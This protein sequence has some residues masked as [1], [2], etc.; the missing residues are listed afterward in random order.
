[1]NKSFN[2]SPI[3][4]GLIVLVSSFPSPV[5]SVNNWV[6]GKIVVSYTTE[7]PSNERIKTAMCIKS[8]VETCCVRRPE[9][10]EQNCLMFS[11]DLG[12]S[13]FSLLGKDI[14]LSY[15]ELSPGGHLYSPAGLHLIAGAAIHRVS[16]DRTAG[17]CPRHLVL[18]DA[19]GLF[20]SFLFE[21]GAHT[22]FLSSSDSSLSGESVTMLDENGW[23]TT[24]NPSFY[25]YR[26]KDGLVFRFG[27]SRSVP[28]TFLKLI[29]VRY[30]T[31]R[32]ETP[33]EIGIEVLRDEDGI[34]R[35]IVGPAKIVLL[36]DAPDGEF[37]YDIVE[38]PNDATT[39]SWQ[40][41]SDGFYVVN[42][43]AEPIVT[44]QIRNPK[45]A[46]SLDVDIRKL[47][48]NATPV[49][50]HFHYNTDLEDFSLDYPVDGYRSFSGIYYG[51]DERTAVRERFKTWNGVRFSHKVSTFS[52]IGPAYR[53]VSETVDPEGLAL[54]TEIDYYETGSRKGLEKAV[55]YPDGNWARFEYDDN[56]RM[57]KRIGPWLDSSFEN[58]DEDS[59]CVSFDYAPFLPCDVPVLSD[60]RPRLVVERTA[61][62]ETKR[63]YYAYP[64]NTIGRV[65]EIEEKA[66]RPGAVFGERGNLRT[67]TERFGPGDGVFLNGRIASIMEPSGWSREFIYER[68]VFNPTTDVFV[69]SDS[70]DSLRTVVLW[71]HPEGVPKRTSSV[72]SF[73]GNELFRC[74]ERQV[75]NGIWVTVSSSRMEYDRSGNRIRTTDLDGRIDEYS[76]G[77]N[78][79]GME[80]HRGWDGRRET[81]VYSPVGQL[82]SETELGL[83]ADGVGDRIHVY[84]RRPDGLLLSVSVTN[85][86]LGAGHV[87]STFEY[88]AADREVVRTDRLGNRTF[89]RWSGRMVVSSNELGTVSRSHY[90]DGRL[91]DS[92]DVLGG[93]TV[94]SYGVTDLGEKW[95]RV[96]FGG[97]G[98]STWT[99]RFEDCLGRIV[100]T[101]ESG[102]NGTTIRAETLFD[103]AGNPT[104]RVESCIA[105]S[106]SSEVISSRLFEYDAEGRRIVECWDLDLDGESNRASVDRIKL[107]RWSFQQ[108]D[109][110]WWSV[111]TGF[112][113]PDVGSDRKVEVYRKRF[114]LSH[115]DANLSVVDVL[116]GFARTNRT[117]I[118][119]D[120]NR[121]LVCEK[122]ALS[123]PVERITVNGRLTEEH[124]FDG[125]WTRFVYGW[126][127]AIRERVRSDS[128]SETFEYD[129]LGRMS[130]WS[131]SDG[132]TTRFVYDR[133][134]RIAEKMS[135]AGR[136]TQY[137]YDA[138]NRLTNRWDGETGIEFGYDGAGRLA[139]R[140][141]VEKQFVSHGG[142]LS[143]SSGESATWE[144]PCE[145]GW[146]TG[147]VDSAENRISYGYS[148]DGRLL[149]RTWGRGTMASYGY[150]ETTQLDEVAYSDGTPSIRLFHDRLGRVTES[151]VDGFETN[152]FEYATDGHLVFEDRNGERLEYIYDAER[153][154][155]G[156][157]LGDVST[158]YEYDDFGRIVHARLGDLSVALEY[159]HETGRLSRIGNDN[160][161]RTLEYDGQ[162]GRLRS[163]W[164]RFGVGP[165]FGISYQYDLDGFP[166]SRIQIGSIG[167]ITN[168]FEH[169]SSGR[170][171]SETENG[172]FLHYEYGA[173]GSRKLV[174]DSSGNVSSNE[175]DNAGNIAAVCMNGQ[176]FSRE[177][178]RDGNVIRLENG[179]SLNWDGENRLIS[180]DAG[181]CRIRYRYD[182]RSRLSE[183]VV[184]DETGHRLETRSFRWNGYQLIREDVSTDS[185]TN[186]IHYLWSRAISNKELEEYRESHLLGAILDGMPLVAISDGKGN[187]LSYLSTNGTVVAQCRFDAFGR[188][189]A[190]SGPVGLFSIWQFS[191]VTDRET[192]FV[193]FPKRVYRPEEGRWLSCDKID[194]IGTMLVSNGE[195][196][197]SLI[198]R[199]NGA[200]WF[201]WNGS[202]I[203][204]SHE[205]CHN[206]PMSW[207]DPLGFVAED[208]ADE[209]REP[210]QIDPI[211]LQ[212]SQPESPPEQCQEG[213]LWVE[214]AETPPKDTDFCSVP[215]II[216]SLLNMDKDNPSGSCSFESPCKKH[217]YC[218]ASCDGSNLIAPSSQKKSC[219]LSF[220]FALLARCRTCYRADREVDGYQSKSKKCFLWAFAYYAAVVLGGNSGYE[221]DNQLKRCECRCPDGK[222]RSN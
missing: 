134:G 107:R 34:P 160:W 87:D 157:T 161:V 65:L 28:E 131:L 36:P 54:T 215:G 45:P 82:L 31:L 120:R 155:T 209:P 186:R 81:F 8:N 116:D 79:C 126:D 119:V 75:T 25:D 173:G 110:G 63:T 150:D 169:D 163:I 132:R 103:A 197:L 62:Q 202:G 198:F 52:K 41:T 67:T 42:P 180:A 99:C 199:L 125:S 33:D 162:T 7:M 3:L 30:P 20:R 32:E 39:T 117:E 35:Q 101:E 218:Y 102:S 171:V 148:D 112:V 111:E 96:D 152:R 181:S 68:G 221:D 216:V 129:G 108:D 187:V 133:F 89:H 1:M 113:F 176:W 190:E 172:S 140:A 9:A 149:S 27:A 222:V 195:T 188:T 19:N 90:V 97:P 165:E 57:T 38:F 22:A 17:G 138:A 86:A 10:P 144:Y 11:V 21:D 115:P 76:Y 219:D 60:D 196:A 104:S 128:P 46:E 217:D 211:P 141:F 73:S 114:R 208:G 146:P 127:G 167:S 77:S 64:T 4:F 185:S 100:R 153:R 170:L 80:S 205:F 56:R 207:R 59:V 136:A 183:R 93:R 193:F 203:E 53:M 85:V 50:W 51:E 178:D 174:R 106:G 37:G 137:F 123:L 43:E 200:G 105:V 72:V 210:I 84:E 92:L 154:G 15:N 214:K 109:E 18:C 118:S 78:C 40:R 156:W 130:A 212:P 70:G 143:V 14:V 145:A 184:E 158:E 12:Q 13:P 98:G 61:G 204:G 26:D 58:P 139:E 191:K 159:D 2:S 121:A 201:V 23:A 66:C 95:S 5:L 166:I 164:N 16:T 83:D 91:K 177:N 192:G 142:T 48:G 175:I 151:I 124:E 44:W 220:F 29:R 69:P 94:C 24:E 49:V 189:I 213:R 179:T 74:E 135:P 55:R 182:W 194:E 71:T 168:E 122:T 206:A 6:E 147:R 47:V 88:D